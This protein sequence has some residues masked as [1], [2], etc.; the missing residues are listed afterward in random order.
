MQKKLKLRFSI[1]KPLT[2]YIEYNFYLAEVMPNLIIHGHLKKMDI[3]ENRNCINPG[4][5][6]KF[7]R[8]ETNL[9][10]IWNLLIRKLEC[11]WSQEE[12]KYCWVACNNKK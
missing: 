10:M 7:W 5:Y 11:L 1:S 9:F 12:L 2:K 3:K 6:F 4:N 8:N